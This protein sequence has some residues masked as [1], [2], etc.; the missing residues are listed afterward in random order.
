MK[1]QTCC[2]TGHRYLPKEKLPDIVRQLEEV[3]ENLIAQG[4]IYYGCGGAIG[5][6]LLARETVLKLKKKHP[7]IRLIMVLPC[8]EQD[9]KW[10]QSDK[11]RYRALLKVCDKAVYVQ[12]E[13]DEGCMFKRNRYLVDHNSV[14]VAYMVRQ[15][16]GSG[17]T[18]SYAR[19]KK[20][21]VINV[22]V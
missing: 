8:V 10:R 7:Q 12:R 17:C 19:S 2:F 4:V 5:F 13:Y 11:D 18:V 16:S 15:Q 21:L 22:A 3:I 9:R 6:D 1:N 20:V 14:C